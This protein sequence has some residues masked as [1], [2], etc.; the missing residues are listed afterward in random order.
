MG[1]CSLNRARF[2]VATYCLLAH[3]K[4]NVLERIV[5]KGGPEVLRSS[6]CYFP[7][8]VTSCDI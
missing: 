3:T 6:P 4:E 2:P 1:L 5:L 7:Q 8:F